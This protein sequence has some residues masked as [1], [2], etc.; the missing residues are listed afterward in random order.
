MS[1]PSNMERLWSVGYF[2]CAVLISWIS[3][4]GAFNVVEMEIEIFFI[5]L[6]PARNS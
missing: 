5:W 4:S 1:A 3:P 2:D 6:I